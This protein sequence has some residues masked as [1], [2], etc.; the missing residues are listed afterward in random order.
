MLICSGKNAAPT[1]GIAMKTR[2]VTTRLNSATSKKTGLFGSRRTRP[3]VPGSISHAL[4]GEFSKQELETLGRLG[5]LVEVA[6][7][8]ELIV[9]GRVGNEAFV[10]AAGTATVTRDGQTLATLSAGAIF[11]ESALLSLEPRNA[12]VIATSN[13][14]VFVL[15]P[16]EFS[17]LM[18]ACPR[19]AGEIID[20]SAR[21]QQH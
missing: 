13:L 10:V 18:A 16:R 8:H 20:T 11:G 15:N 6:A 9:E 19:L 1:K 14:S 5:T 2:E 21:R 7:G 17:S 12:T 4:G 3:G